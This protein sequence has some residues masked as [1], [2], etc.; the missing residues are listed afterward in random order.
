M[1][2]VQWLGNFVVQVYAELDEELQNNFAEYL[3][4]RGINEDLGA[5]LLQLMHDKEQR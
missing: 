1:V 3:A 5:F 4:E 2:R